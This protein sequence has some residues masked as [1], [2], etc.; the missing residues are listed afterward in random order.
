MS[1][2]WIVACPRWRLT[3]NSRIILFHLGVSDLALI[4]A[5]AKAA[6][7]VDASPRLVEDRRT[8]PVVREREHQVFAFRTRRKFH[9]TPP[10]TFCRASRCVRSRT[11]G[12]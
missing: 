4:N 12:G 11:L 10:T 9:L 6:F 7:I 2:S 1:R 8:V 3:V 5:Q